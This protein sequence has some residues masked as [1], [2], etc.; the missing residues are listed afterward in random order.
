MTMWEAM[1]ATVPATVVSLTVLVL[2]TKSINTR[3]DD[4]SKQFDK[5]IDDIGARIDDMGKLF[6]KRIDDTNKRIDDLR[7]L[8]MTIFGDELKRIMGKKTGTDN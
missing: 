1:L 4:M 7:N 6:D 5:R 3:I 8:F 2:I